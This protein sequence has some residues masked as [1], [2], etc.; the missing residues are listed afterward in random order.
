MTDLDSDL[1]AFLRS[2]DLGDWSSF[3]SGVTGVSAIIFIGA[4]C[5][6]A[7]R[8]L[9]GDSLDPTRA[10]AAVAFNGA[11]EGNIPGDLLA[12]ARLFVDINREALL[13]HWHCRISTD[14]MQRRL[15][16]ISP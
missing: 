6:G 16:P 14:E 7:S 11:A 2:G 10:T 9:L 3:G 15:R 8:I 4:G 13:D 12:Q 1:G 5:D